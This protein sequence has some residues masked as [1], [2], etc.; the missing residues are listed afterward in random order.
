MTRTSVMKLD[1]GERVATLST[2]EE[3]HFDKALVATGANVNRLKAEGDELDGI[4]YLR[5][6]AN[7]DA[8]REDAQSGERV[9][10]IGGSYI[11]TEVAA[12]LTGAYDKQCAIVMQEDVTLE[13]QFGAEVGGFFQRALE[14]HGVE[15]PRR[16][17]ARPLRGH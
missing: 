5:A 11:G 10:L 6:I 1:A 9:V 15:R 13:R 4:H 14:E 2:K 16:R 3:I 12:S 7:S 8:I 17:V